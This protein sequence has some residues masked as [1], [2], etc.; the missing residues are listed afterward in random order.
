MGTLQVRRTAVIP[1]GAMGQTFWQT[2]VQA[3]ALIEEYCRESW[4][5]VQPAP[6]VLVL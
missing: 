1:A 4:A 3:L 5:L 6:S 2:E